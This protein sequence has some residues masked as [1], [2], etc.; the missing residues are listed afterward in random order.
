MVKG[1]ALLAGLGLVLAGCGSG[2]DPASQRTSVA[3]VSDTVSG[4]QANKTLPDSAKARA[5]TQAETMQKMQQ[6]AL[7]QSAK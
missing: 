6:Q 7:T 2:E 4:I 1:P 5:A 3:S